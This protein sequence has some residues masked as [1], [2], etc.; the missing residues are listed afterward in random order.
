MSD[1]RRDFHK[2]VELAI[3]QAAYPDVHPDFTDAGWDRMAAAVLDATGLRRMVTEL[4]NIREQARANRDAA[5]E[6]GD[7]VV[8]REWQM[9]Y[10]AAHTAVAKIES[11][12]V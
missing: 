11:R 6:R 10:A 7:V 4:I 8:A 12:D 2:E 9:F 5:S 1:P 3:A